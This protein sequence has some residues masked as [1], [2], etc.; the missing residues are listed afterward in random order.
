[1]NMLKGVALQ[2]GATL[3]FTI[4]AALVR[5]VSERLPT[6]EVMFA[7]SFFALFPLLALLVVRNEIGSA[8]RTANPFGHV[9]R[10]TI[11]V[12]GMTFTFLGL[13]RLPLADATA[14][15]FAAPLLTVVLAA[16]FLGETVRLNRWLAVLAG[17][18]GIVVMLWPHLDGG[19]GRSAHGALGAMFSLVAAFCTAGAMI[20]IRHLTA[21]ETTA[22]I[23]FYFQ[24]L[25]AVAALAT[26]PW[27]WTLPNAG[28]AMLLL[29]IGFLGGVGQILVTESFRA[30][31]A[32]LVAP[33]AYSAMLWSLLLGF[34][35]FGEIPP[36]LVVLGAAIVIAAGLFVVWN[37][38]RGPVDG[39][40]G[41]VA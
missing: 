25:A 9:V 13:A 16:L 22:A 7:R 4:M 17:L 18:C 10:G 6:G 36:L 12:C 19:F 23:V 1:M 24:A 40:T 11:G 21:T 14:I 31:P 27:G 32:S 3:L 26:A 8:V 37:E 5:I 15:G 38:R 39:G 28:D 41:P 29:A 35:L 20:Q 30:A 2:I 33:F 34:I